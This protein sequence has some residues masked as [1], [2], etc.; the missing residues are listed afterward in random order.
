MREPD[1][2]SKGMR[3]RTKCALTGVGH[4][5]EQAKRDRDHAPWTHLV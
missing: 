1:E 3:A 2:K 4:P 5:N